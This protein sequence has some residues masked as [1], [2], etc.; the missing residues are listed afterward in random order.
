MRLYDGITFNPNL[1]PPIKYCYVWNSHQLKISCRM[2][3]CGPITRWHPAVPP[4]VPCFSAPTLPGDW[5]VS[6]SCPHSP[7]C[8][9]PGR[10][11]G[12]SL[13]LAASWLSVLLASFCPGQVAQ[14]PPCQQP[15][16]V[17]HVRLIVTTK[18]RNHTL[19]TQWD[20]STSLNP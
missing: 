4:P 14:C 13:S 3:A 16:K 19:S 1:K 11:L 9:G 6:P 2:D 10:G 12:S 7:W 20:R 15:W 18:Y 5:P 8:A 17:N